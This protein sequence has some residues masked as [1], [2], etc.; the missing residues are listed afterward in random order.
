MPVCVRPP[1]DAAA[2]R[3]PL[4]PSGRNM[5]RRTQRRCW[6]IRF[7][8]LPPIAPIDP[9]Q[10]PL[11]T[12]AAGPGRE[13]GD[14]LP[15]RLPSSWRFPCRRQHRRRVLGDGPPDGMP[16]RAECARKSHRAQRG[17]LTV[18]AGRAGAV[19][20]RNAVY[21]S[22]SFRWHPRRTSPIPGYTSRPKRFIDVP[23]LR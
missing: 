9:E 23:W 15:L 16:Q 2:A 21:S 22:Y 5:T 6:L 1:I 19:P 10:P 17:P 7:Y 11:L 20:A 12:G 18:G 8:Q 4:T 3:K 13:G 14:G